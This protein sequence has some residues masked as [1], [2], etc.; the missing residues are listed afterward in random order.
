MRA[1]SRNTPNLHPLTQRTRAR[2]SG[3]CRKPGA[4]IWIVN[5]GLYCGKVLEIRK[6]KSCSLHF[7]KLKTESFY[8]RAGRLKVKIK[9]SPQSPAI[10]EFE[11]AAGQCM[12]IPPGLVH[13][14]YALRMPS[15]TNS[16]PSTSTATRTGSPPALDPTATRIGGSR[17]STSTATRTGSP[18]APDP[19]DYPRPV[20]ARSV[21]QNV[22]GSSYRSCRSARPIQLV[23]RIGPTRPRRRKCKSFT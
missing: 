6:G 2:P 22:E 1:L 10:E 18:T 16:P 5:C 3:S 19:R 12:D 23:N 15:F 7:H 21:V 8:L 13:Q 14:M 4:A 17:P 11:L 20:R 9:R